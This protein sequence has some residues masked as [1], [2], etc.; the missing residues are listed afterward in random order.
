M[1]PHIDLSI[2]RKALN[3]ISVLG[4]I[5]VGIVLRF[6]P[7][8][9]VWIAWTVSFIVL[10]DAGLYLHDFLPR[11]QAGTWVLLGLICFI[12]FVYAKQLAEYLTCPPVE[13]RGR[14][15]ASALPS[16]HNLCLEMKERLMRI[17]PAGK[18]K[19]FSADT[20]FLFLGSDIG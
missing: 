19:P 16:P 4:F 20:V 15:I 18:I 1:K 5:V 14:L 9:A 11:Y 3:A 7:P 2:V 12:G 6:D 8:T 13:Y 10:F 17:E